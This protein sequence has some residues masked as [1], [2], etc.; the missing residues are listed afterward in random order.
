M[1][2]TIGGFLLILIA[3]GA[4]LLLGLPVAVLLRRIT[5]NDTAS[6][7]VGTGVWLLS[8]F[9]M[10]CYISLFLDRPERPKAGLHQA[11]PLSKLETASIRLGFVFA[12]ISVAIAEIAGAGI[13]TTASV[14]VACAAIGALI[15]LDVQ[16]RARRRRTGRADASSAG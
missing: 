7:A 15:G 1:L 8:F 6:N 5:G 11:S 2:R 16:R 14:A 4:A 10:L 9:V 3:F 13:A 12:I